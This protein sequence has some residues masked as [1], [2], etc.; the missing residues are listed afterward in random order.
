MK[1]S[2]LLPSTRTWLLAQ[3][4]LTSAENALQPLQVEASHRHFYRLKRAR[5]SLVIMQ[6]PPDLEN[7]D[8]F[9]TTAKIFNHAGV[10]VPQLIDYDT[11]LGVFVMTDVGTTQ[12]EACYS[13]DRR[14]P[15]L[16]TAIDTLAQLSRVNDAAIPPYTHERLQDELTIF[17]TWFLQSYL[18]LD[19]AI[20]EQTRTTLVSAIDSQ[21][22]C[23]VHRDYHCRNLL[24]DGE[25][26]GVVDFQD[27]LMGPAL[28]DIASLLRDCYVTFPEPDVK[29]WLSYFLVKSPYFEDTATASVQLAFDF[30]AI[31]RQLKAIGIF[32]RLHLRDNKHTHLTYIAPLLERLL[33]LCG[34][35]PELQQL[36]DIL[37]QSTKRLGER[38]VPS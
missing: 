20:D 36:V 38:A 34:C 12:L 1:D 2:T 19:A 9:L 4:H 27:A 31:Q 33:V 13:T 7:N 8:A 10:P 32:A 6:S 16:R 35:Y 11:E 18:N 23:C 30:T 25:R 37:S 5:D 24:F 22:K 17:D 26:F 15:A 14:E 3:G 21:P 29:Q 28:Y